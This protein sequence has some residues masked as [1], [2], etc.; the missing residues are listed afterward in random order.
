MKLGTTVLV[1]GAGSGIGISVLKSL[2]MDGHP[3]VL[4]IG[5][6]CNPLASGL[7]A[8]A[9]FG[10]VIPPANGSGYKDALVSVCAK[11]D[12]DIIIPGCDPELRALASMAGQLAHDTGAAVMVAP[13]WAVRKMSD[14]TI[15]PKWLHD[16]GFESPRTT[17]MMGEM[18]AS[19]MP[20]PFVAKPARGSGSADTHVVRD[21]E[22]WT[23][24]PDRL[25]CVQEYLEGDE[26]TTSVMVGRNGRAYDIM[27]LRRVTPKI[28]EG[29]AMIARHTY[30]PGTMATAE[31]VS[32]AE[33]LKTV[34]CCNIQWKFRG[35][36]IVPFEI[37][38]RFPGSTVICAAAG[39]NGPVM[40]VQD[41]IGNP[42]KAG[43]HRRLMCT[44]HLSE[45]FIDHDAGKAFTLEKM[46]CGS[47]LPEGL[48][49]SA[50]PW[51]HCSTP[52]V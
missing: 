19:P 7:Y 38:M 11:Y 32:L 22:S 44:R 18:P 33:Q 13:W 47:V 29:H 43:P 45:V 5:V 36:R 21:I 3:D 51:S 4:K 27:T 20:F 30:D 26:F 50:P 9:D 46:T 42:V 39:M 6:D 15:M 37:N 16:H 31:L 23:M 2:A 41:I 24:D 48:D 10:V 17:T 52:P 25:Y 49:T 1:T 8:G 34:G 14:K 40:A 28:G 35:L 12:V